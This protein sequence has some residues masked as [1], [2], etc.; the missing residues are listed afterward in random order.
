MRG[1]WPDKNKMQAHRWRLYVF[2]A[3]LTVVTLPMIQGVLRPFGETEEPGPLNAA[4]RASAQLHLRF[5]LLLTVGLL[6][7]SALR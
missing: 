5:G 4:V 6:I 3:V 1:G 2:A 7:A